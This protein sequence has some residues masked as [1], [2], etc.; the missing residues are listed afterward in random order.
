MS[1]TVMR[2]AAALEDLG[3]REHSPCMCE[4]FPARC[5]LSSKET[6]YSKQSVKKN[7]IDI[8]MWK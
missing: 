5:F 7:D 3:Q 8:N 4:V 6:V 2:K 1:A